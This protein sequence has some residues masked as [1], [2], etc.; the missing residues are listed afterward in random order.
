MYNKYDRELN[1]DIIDT[2]DFQNLTIFDDV[3]SIYDIEELV[4]QEK[5]DLCVVDFVQNVQVP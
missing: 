2:L 5:P 4:M 3:Y 1:D